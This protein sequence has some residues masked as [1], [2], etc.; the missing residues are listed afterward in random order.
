[1]T[2]GS[3]GRVIRAPRTPKVMGAAPFAPATVIGF[4]QLLLGAFGIVAVGLALLFANSLSVLMVVA[5]AIRS[6]VAALTCLAGLWIADGR[7]RGALLA[8][9]CDLVQLVVLAV[10]AQ[11]G[12]ELALAAALVVATV[13]LLPSLE[14]PMR[15]PRSA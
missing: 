3:K 10:T 4:A 12:V 6:V 11:W 8:I 2:R 5:V 1:M 9:V 7:R 14:V 13:W 15:P